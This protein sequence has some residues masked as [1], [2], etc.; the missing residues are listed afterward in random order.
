MQDG[1]CSYWGQRRCFPH[2]SFP[3]PNA[4]QCS[5]HL[6]AQQLNAKWINKQYTSVQL[7]ESIDWAQDIA[8]VWKSLYEKMILKF[9]R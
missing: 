1:E 7:F 8:K 3:T 4:A 9:E 6:G 5:Y 2:F